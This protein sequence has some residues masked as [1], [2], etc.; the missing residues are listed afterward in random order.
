[1][2]DLLYFVYILDFLQFGKNFLNQ[3]LGDCFNQ[4]RAFFSL[5][6]LLN[7]SDLGY[8]WWNMHIN[9]FIQMSA[10]EAFL[11]SYRCKFH[12]RFTASDIK[13]LTVFNLVPGANILV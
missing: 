11:K 2:Y 3:F 6:T 5:Y 7:F 4:Y 8:P 9:S 1:M 10:G 13:I 12:S